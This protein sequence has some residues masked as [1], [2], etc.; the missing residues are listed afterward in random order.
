MNKST[1]VPAFWRAAPDKAHRHSGA[2]RA[3][4][5]DPFLGTRLEGATIS[6]FHS[7]A[8]CE[9]LWREAATRCT[10]FVFQTYEWQA[11]YHATIGVAEGAMPCIVHVA[12]RA[13][14]PLLLLPFGIYRQGRFR[15]LRFLGGVV[16]DYNA[17]LIAPGFAEQVGTGE[18]AALW[19]QIIDRLPPFDLFWFRRMPQ[20]IEGEPNAMLNLAGA[21]HT[22]DAYAARIPETVEAFRSARSPK[23]FSDGRRQ[24]RRLAEKGET[25]LELQI[26]GEAALDT[27][28]VMARQKSRRYQESGVRDIFA[29]PGYLDFYR[30]LT[31]GPLRLPGV[32]VSR[33]QVGDTT[34]AT[35]WGALHNGR[36]YWLMPG[37]EAGEWGRFSCGRLLLESAFE[38][39]VAH[40]MRVLDLTVGDERYKLDWA[41]H[42]LALYEC[43]GARTLKGAAYV[44]YQRS[45]EALRQNE[46]LRKV[47]LRLRTLVRSKG[48]Q[49]G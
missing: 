17:P 34:V 38:W 23:L 42:S 46:R 26:E 10:G 45:R 8:A 31:E 3:R 2:P 9:A 5:R 28:A 32:H 25:S 18:F 1:A 27:V 36:L 22:R 30:A 43:L 33:L 6:L 40:K 7:V 37:Y 47:A 29:E 21:I 15:V 41:D 20:T 24:R 35:H 12:D 19:R 4:S 49:R 16:T 39:C 44:A 13:G 14:A 48:P 11:A